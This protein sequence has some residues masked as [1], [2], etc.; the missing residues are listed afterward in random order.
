MRNEA[1]SDKSKIFYQDFPHSNYMTNT[2]QEDEEMEHSVHV[3]TF[4]Q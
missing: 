3:S 1:P 2:T 4:V